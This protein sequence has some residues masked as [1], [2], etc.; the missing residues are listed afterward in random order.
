MELSSSSGRGVSLRQERPASPA[1]GDL[2]IILQVLLRQ[3]DRVAGTTRELGGAGCAKKF[4][5]GSGTPE[6]HSA[7]RLNV[8]LRTLPFRQNGRSRRASGSR[9]GLTFPASMQPE[10]LL[11]V[12]A[13]QA[14]QRRGV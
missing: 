14:F 13:N 9:R 6:V 10:V 2:A 8:R 12:P 1:W 5:R 4:G 11:G 7:D 3:A